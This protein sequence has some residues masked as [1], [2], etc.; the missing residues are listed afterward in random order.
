MVAA[1]EGLYV[2]G[3]AS[4][5]AF[6]EVDTWWSVAA[7]QRSLTFI[8]RLCADQGVEVRELRG[9]SPGEDAFLVATVGRLGDSQLIGTMTALA[10]VG[11]STT[12]ISVSFEHSGDAPL[13][14]EDMKQTVRAALAAL[15]E[16]G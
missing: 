6:Q 1:R 9:L 2:C 8:R 10:R 16:A 4:A 11:A 13:P 12:V 5:G 14:I 15:S 7:A 3:D